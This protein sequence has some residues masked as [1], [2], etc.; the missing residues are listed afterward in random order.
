VSPENL[1]RILP[2]IRHASPSAYIRMSAILNK[3]HENSEVDNWEEYQVGIFP[4]LLS[5]ISSVMQSSLDVPHMENNM[6]NGTQHLITNIVTTWKTHFMFG[7]P[8]LILRGTIIKKLRCFDVVTVVQVQNS[9]GVDGFFKMLSRNRSLLYDLV[10]ENKRMKMEDDNVEIADENVLWEECPK[11]DDDVSKIVVEF[12]D[13][14]E[15]VEEGKEVVCMVVPAF[16]YS[17]ARHHWVG[18]TKTPDT[19][20]YWVSGTMVCRELLSIS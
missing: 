3:D 4:Q 14:I 18:E 7:H 11:P 17:N 10:N 16:T 13:V 20:H 19:I 9:F 15:E 12:K 2:I 6:E 1:L 5:G 8:P